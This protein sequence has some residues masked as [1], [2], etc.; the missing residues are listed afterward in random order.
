MKLEIGDRVMIAQGAPGYTFPG[1]RQRVG[2]VT[3]LCSTRPPLPPRCYVRWDGNKAADCFAV[4]NLY[5]LRAGVPRNVTAARQLVAG[6][7]AGGA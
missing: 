1:F 7:K 4:A 2:T 5:R 3:R 6:S